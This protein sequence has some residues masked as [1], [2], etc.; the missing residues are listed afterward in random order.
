MCNS[1]IECTPLPKL[2]ESAQICY[3]RKANYD[4]EKTYRD[5]RDWCD[6]ISND[7]K[8][9]VLIIKN[10]ILYCSFNLVVGRKILWYFKLKI[11]QGL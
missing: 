4:T 11:L 5:F 6:R 7:L 1:E 10:R 8:K 9:N 2:W 3:L